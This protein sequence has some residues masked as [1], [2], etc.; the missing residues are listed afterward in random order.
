MDKNVRWEV[1]ILN[2]DIRKLQGIGYKPDDYT[3][4]Q[5]ITP[6]NPIDV[7]KYKIMLKLYEDTK[8]KYFKSSVWLIGIT[9]SG[10]HKEI[11]NRQVL[12]LMASKQW[13]LEWDKDKTDW[14]VFGK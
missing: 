11:F 3:G 2:D 8:E 5:V 4:G 12:S 14:S 9:K 10:K 7:T 6:F 1:I 13:L